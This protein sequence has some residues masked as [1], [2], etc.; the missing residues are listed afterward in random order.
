MVLEYTHWDDANGQILR[1]GA[2]DYVGPPLTWVH[3]ASPGSGQDLVSHE[4]DDGQLKK[5]A[6]P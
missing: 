4:S 6:F 3:W 1:G 5:V 2:E